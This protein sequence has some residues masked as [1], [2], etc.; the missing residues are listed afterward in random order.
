MNVDVA[1]KKL[2]LLG[3]GIHATGTPTRIAQHAVQQIEI[4]AVLFDSHPL[5][6]DLDTRWKRSLQLRRLLIFQVH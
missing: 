5:S 1:G 4:Q 3:K 6:I 2:A